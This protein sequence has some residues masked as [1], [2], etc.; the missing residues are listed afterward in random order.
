M[1]TFGPPARGRLDGK[2]HGK[3]RAIGSGFFRAGPQRVVDELY[4]SEIKGALAIFVSLFG[5][6]KLPLFGLISRFPVS[7]SFDY[8]ARI[9]NIFGNFPVVAGIVNFCA[10]R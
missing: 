9:A 2:F 8:L 5:A 1:R 4:S 6:E 3:A 10:P 7:A